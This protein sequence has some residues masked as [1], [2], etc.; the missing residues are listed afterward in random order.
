MVTT[1]N[2]V[3]ERGKQ[4]SSN[5]CVSKYISVYVTMR[6]RE[7][8]GFLCLVSNLSQVVEEASHKLSLYFWEEEEQSTPT[9]R[10]HTH[11][12]IVYLQSKYFKDTCTVAKASASLCCLKR[13]F[14]STVLVL[15]CLRHLSV[16]I[17]D[18]GLTM[19]C[20]TLQH[21]ST[22]NI[23]WH[24]SKWR[25]KAQGPFLFILLACPLE[26]QTRSVPPSGCAPFNS[27]LLLQQL[28]RQYQD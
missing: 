3:L 26:D 6:A 12:S 28:R 8:S 24:E 20:E 4:Q 21:I 9:T 18:I 23:Q 25:T 10:W 13:M 1:Q 19:L 14:Q 15:F 17:Q 11:V 16:P 2:A 27:L 7:C 22:Q 5:L